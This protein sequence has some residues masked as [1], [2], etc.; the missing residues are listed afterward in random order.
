LPE[1]QVKLTISRKGE[2]QPID[3]TITRRLVHVD[4]VQSGY[5]SDIKKRGK[6]YLAM[7]HYDRAIADFNEAIQLD[8]KDAVAYYNRGLAKRAIGDAAGGDADIVRARQLNPNI[9]E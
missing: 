5:V 6:V 9:G 7:H 4:K 2:P 3:L 1:S 8:L